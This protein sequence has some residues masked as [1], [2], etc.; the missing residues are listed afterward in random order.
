MKPSII[1]QGP[2]KLFKIFP[3]I[4]HLNNRFQELYL[5]NQDISVGESLMLWEGH[6][7]FK[8]YLCLKASKFGIRRYVLCDTTTG[9]LWLCLVYASKDT[10][11]DSTL[12]IADTNKTA[13]TVLKLGEPLLNLGQTLWMDNCCTSPCLAKTLKT[14]HKMDCVD[15]QK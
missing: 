5:P 15:T 3:V 1:F 9:Y 2:K 11:L 12:S 6:L 8:Q 14:V 10:K 13:A 7:S 4:S